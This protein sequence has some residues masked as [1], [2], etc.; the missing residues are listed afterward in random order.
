MLG[1]KVA[2]LV[3]KNVDVAGITAVHV[4]KLVAAGTLVNVT[5]GSSV[6]GI[7]VGVSVSVGSGVTEAIADALG[8]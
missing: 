4:G 1:D 2:V 8:V 6:A 3:G 5:V 7:S